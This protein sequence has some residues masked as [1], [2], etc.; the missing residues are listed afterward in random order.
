MKDLTEILYSFDKGK[1]HI[2]KFI[3]SALIMSKSIKMQSSKVINHKA[4]ILR[5]PGIIVVEGHLKLPG[6][7]VNALQ[8]LLLSFCLLPIFLLHVFGVKKCTFNLIQADFSFLVVFFKD[9]CFFIVLQ[10]LSFTFFTEILEMIL[11]A[12]LF[13]SVN[14]SSLPCLA[15]TN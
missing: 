4:E 9:N 11:L 15:A 10:A 14:I 7:A 2:R 8:V 3:L 5:K 13:L 6:V 12:F 1:L